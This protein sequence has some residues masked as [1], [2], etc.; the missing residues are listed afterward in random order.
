MVD[1]I[2]DDPR[3]RWQEIILGNTMDAN[4]SLINYGRVDFSNQLS[5]FST[6]LCSNLRMNTDDQ[7]L[8]YCYY[9]MRRH[10]CSAKGLYLSYHDWL[11]S[12]A[13]DVDGRIRFIDIGCGPATCGIAFAEQ[14]EGQFPNIHYTGIDTSVAMKTMAEKM[15]METTGGRMQMDFKTSLHELDDGY[16]SSV[17]EVPNLVVFNMSYF[18]LNVDCTFTENLADR[19]VS[20]MRKYPLNRYVFIIQ[21]SDHDTKIRS[22]LVFKNM[23]EQYVETIKA[24]R[25]TFCYELGGNPKILPFCYEIWKSK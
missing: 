11:A 4:M 22:F 13:E 19:I 20:V 23:L 21:H 24:E 5:L 1:V 6:A 14:M 12:M 9:I 3:T 2:K 10:Y 16:W 18:F 15:L 8:L 17:S 7:V 25:S